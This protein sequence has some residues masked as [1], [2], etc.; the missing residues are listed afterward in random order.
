MARAKKKVA[1]KVKRA[2]PEQLDL[3]AA[4]EARPYPHARL[5]LIVTQVNDKF[6]RIE[7]TQHDL[8]HV[9]QL[10]HAEL[11]SVRKTK[12]WT[13]EERQRLSAEVG[14]MTRTDGEVDWNVLAEIHDCTVTEVRAM[15]K[16]IEGERT[17]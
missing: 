14:L 1:R 8:A 6:E 2:A 13:P 16:E 7:Q 3:V 17:L 12:Q 10:L 11:K 5:D 9:V 15:L 4:C